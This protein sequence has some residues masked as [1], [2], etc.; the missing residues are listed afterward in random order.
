VV[1]DVVAVGV[2]QADDAEAV[3]VRPSWP[4]PEAAEHAGPCRVV[5]QRAVPRVAWAVLRI[6]V[7][8]RVDDVDR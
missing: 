5:E 2:D 6:E 1:L 3:R 7:D 4:R 8:L